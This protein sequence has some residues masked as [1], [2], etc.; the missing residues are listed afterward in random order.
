MNRYLP[1]L[2][3]V[4]LCAGCTKQPKA[5]AVSA[6]K[7]DKNTTKKKIGKK[8]K[9]TAFTYRN[10]RQEVSRD[11][12]GH[13]EFIRFDGEL[14]VFSEAHS[15]YS[16]GGRLTGERAGMRYE[17]SDELLTELDE[18]LQTKGLL[19]T[20]EHKPVTPDRD[21]VMGSYNIYGQSFSVDYEG[22]TTTINVSSNT[23]RD[24]FRPKE[25][26]VKEPDPKAIELSKKLVA[27]KTFLNALRFKK[28]A[29]HK[30]YTKKEMEDQTAMRMHGHTPGEVPNEIQRF[31]FS[32]FSG[33]FTKRSAGKFEHPQFSVNARNNRLIVAHRYPTE[34]VRADCEMNPEAVKKFL[35]LVDKY[36]LQDAKNHLALSPAMPEYGMNIV[37]YEFKATFRNQWT[38]KSSIRFYDVAEA[39]KK[40][41]DGL[42]SRFD[43]FDKELRILLKSKDCPRITY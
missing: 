37:K 20:A 22:K 36:K 43:G 29:T 33:E 26:P 12:N 40:D 24:L 10:F 4:L 5:G 39:R 41:K 31:D 42:I 35:K 30:E 18:Y 32:R 23:A 1:L 6:V 17:L 16:P 14:L 28:G 11:S 2:F 3:I 13:T 9:L 38:T 25:E 8:M 7:I 34:H 15:G 27:L 19:I 21:L